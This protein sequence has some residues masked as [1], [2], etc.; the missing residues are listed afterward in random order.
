MVGAALCWRD[1][2]AAAVRT[3]L[4]E[5]VGDGQ[6]FDTAATGQQVEDEVH[7]DHLVGILCWPQLLPLRGQELGLLT[8]ADAQL[9]FAVQGDRSSC[10]LPAETPGT[11]GRAD[12]DSQ[13]GDAP[14]LGRPAWPTWRRHGHRRVVESITRKPRKA[15]SPPLADR[16]QLAHAPDCLALALRG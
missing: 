15:A 6:A 10:G 3:Y 14:A 5:V 16:R 12:G 7:A 9:R 13:S 4:V 8:S 2:T 1:A 11:A